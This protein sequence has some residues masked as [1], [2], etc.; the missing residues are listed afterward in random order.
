MGAA[1]I[2]PIYLARNERDNPDEPLILANFGTPTEYLIEATI[3]RGRHYNIDNP[4]FYRELK[5][6]S[7]VRR[8]LVVY[9]EVGDVSRWKESVFGFEGSVRVNSV[10]DY[11]KGQS[12]CLNL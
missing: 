10:E 2:P 7:M 5:S 11:S 6:F 9:Q 12:I 1:T 4:R 8:G 3:F